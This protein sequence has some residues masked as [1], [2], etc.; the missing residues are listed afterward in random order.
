M[1]YDNRKLLD[2]AHIMPCMTQFPHKCG[3]W[4]GCDPAHSDSSIF[5]RGHGHKSDDCFF[6]AM[7]HHSHMLLDTRAFDRELKFYEWL[8]A[9]AETQRYLYEQGWLIYVGPKGR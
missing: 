8:R 9:Y 6:A 2:S 5:G 7:C 3:G 4:E 1:T